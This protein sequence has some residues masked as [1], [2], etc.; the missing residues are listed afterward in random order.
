MFTEERVVLAHV[1][2]G[3]QAADVSA[4][5]P[6]LSAQVPSAAGHVASDFP[7]AASKREVR[8]AINYSA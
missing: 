3:A 2:H 5:P 8:S 4:R 7:G 1:H 6:G